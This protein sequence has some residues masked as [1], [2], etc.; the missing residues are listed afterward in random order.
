MQA[1]Y[2]AICARI[3][4]PTQRLDRVNASEHGDYRQYYDQVLLDGVAARYAQ[5]L[6][7]FGYAFDGM[8]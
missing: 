8:R 3:G 4:I 5:D 7:L 2:D 1:S 6:E